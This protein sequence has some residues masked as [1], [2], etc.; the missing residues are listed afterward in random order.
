MIS[1]YVNTTCC[2]WSRVSLFSCIICFFVLG[3][4][5]YKKGYCGKAGQ[6]FR[7]IPS[8]DIPRCVGLVRIHKG[9]DVSRAHGID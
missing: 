3:N 9:G 8:S 2:F 6:C 5:R 7:Q 4:T 1:E